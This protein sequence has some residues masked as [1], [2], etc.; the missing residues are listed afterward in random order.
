M[1][2]KELREE[3]ENTRSILNKAIE[4]KCGFSRILDISRVLDCLIE[5]Y[6]ERSQQNCPAGQ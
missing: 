6:L 5:E 3:I 1:T 2:Q 4:N